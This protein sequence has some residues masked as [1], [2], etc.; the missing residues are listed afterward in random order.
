MN[1]TLNVNKDAFSSGQIGSKIWLCEE[2]EKRFD[3]ADRVWIYG[4]WYGITAFLLNSRGNMKIGKI[5]SYDIDPA[6]ESVADMINENWVID[7]WKFK[8]K[9]Q[10]CNALDL[11]WHGPDLVINTST[12]HFESMDW[13]NN[14]PNGTVV[15]LQGNNMPHSDHHVHSD[16][17]VEFVKQFPVSTHLYTGQK[18]FA[19]P[20]WKFTRFMLIGIK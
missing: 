14:I 13:W 2:L 10:D 16:S 3:S 15:A 7:N 18:E 12:E 6:C 5:R 4:G 9:T 20:D 8:A 19:Y 1:Q 11:D 17:L